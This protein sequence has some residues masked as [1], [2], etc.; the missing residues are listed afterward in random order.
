MT[1]GN[2]LKIFK[3]RPR[4][5]IRKFSFPHRIVDI[6]NDLPE[7]VIQAQTVATFE[8]RLDKFLSKQPMLYN[9]KANYK[10]GLKYTGGDNSKSDLDLVQEA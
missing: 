3:N 2:S 5:D 4:L 10:F 9:Y 7:K 6:W 1:R 8:G